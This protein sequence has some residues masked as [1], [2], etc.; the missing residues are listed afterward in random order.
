MTFKNDYR[1]WISKRSFKMSIKDAIERLF[2][3]ARIN[4]LRLI[5]DQAHNV[6]V[7]KPWGWNKILACEMRFAVTSAA[8]VK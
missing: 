3:Y 2:Q 8:Q 7:L 5:T 6:Y 1:F 4:A